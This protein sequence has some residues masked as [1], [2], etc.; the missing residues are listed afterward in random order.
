MELIKNDIVTV[1]TTVFLGRRE[2]MLILLNLYNMF[3]SRKIVKMYS[4]NNYVDGKKIRII[5]FKL[6]RC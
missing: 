5:L 1:Y 2:K 6:Y 3:G 4:I